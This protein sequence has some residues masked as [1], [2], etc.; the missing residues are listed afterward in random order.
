MSLFGDLDFSYVPRK[1]CRKCEIWKPRDQFSPN[2]RMRDRLQ[3]WCRS[4]QAIARKNTKQTKFR[5]SKVCFRCHELKPIEEF[6][7]KLGSS[8]G[9]QSICR[10][11][12]KSRR[13][14][15]RLKQW[16]DITHEDYERMLAIQNGACAI[17]GTDETGSKDKGWFSVDHDHK[18]GRVR[19][20]LCA[21]CNVGLGNMRDSV[22]IL[23]KAI[24]Y[25]ERP[26]I[27]G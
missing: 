12:D 17:C 2:R 7:N 16:Y 13:R 23:K 20:L 26:P 8:D 24:Q 22:E 1:Q 27:H 10:I 21:N 19:G 3:S 5:K 4:C 9:K 25:L 18:T 15:E 6:C 11:C 14:R